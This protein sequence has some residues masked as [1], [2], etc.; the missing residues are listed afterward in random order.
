MRRLELCQRYEP[1][2]QIPLPHEITL[3]SDA[4]W[5]AEQAASRR[6][7]THI[8]RFQ[9]AHLVDRLTC[10]SNTALR[11]RPGRLQHSRRLDDS[12]ARP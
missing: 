2:A 5:S 11:I 4:V 10:P 8:P 12:I 9:A 3:A 7:H 6:G 1:G